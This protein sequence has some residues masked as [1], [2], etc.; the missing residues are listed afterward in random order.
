MMERDIGKKKDTSVMI[1][2]VSGSGH[3][4][5]LFSIGAGRSG[6]QNG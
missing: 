5:V 2:T 6:R 1:A 3:T 4:S